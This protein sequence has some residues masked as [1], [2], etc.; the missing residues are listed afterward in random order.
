MKPVLLPG[1]L[2]AARLNA[3]GLPE[4]CWLE[5]CGHGE[6]VHG[7]GCCVVTRLGFSEQDVADGLEQAPVIE[8]VDPFQCCELGGLEG[9]PGSPSVDHFGL[10]ESVDG[11]GQRIV[12]AVTDTSDRWL[13]VSL[14]KSLGILD[15][16]V[17]GGFNRSSQHVQSYPILAAGREPV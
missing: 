9:T 8:P 2:L 3:P 1:S 6:I 4:A 15:R 17:L 11:F 12:V 14:G 10:V 5:L 13:D 7:S 16:E